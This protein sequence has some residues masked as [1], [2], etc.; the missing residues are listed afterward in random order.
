ME[1]EEVEGEEEEMKGRMKN[2]SKETWVE[3]G[4]KN[5][6]TKEIKN[7]ESEKDPMTE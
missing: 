3:N 6:I 2:K 1:E 4:A 7:N 5:K